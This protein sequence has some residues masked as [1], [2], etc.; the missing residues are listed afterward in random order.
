MNDVKAIWNGT[1]IGLLLMI[2][3]P[4]CSVQIVDAKILIERIQI[5][6]P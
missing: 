3:G 6:S 1:E 2:D 5:R 4:Q